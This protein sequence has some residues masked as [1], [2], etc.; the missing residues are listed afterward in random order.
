MKNGAKN[1]N[2]IDDAD[3]RAVRLPG[4]RVELLNKRSIRSD[5][6]FVLYWMQASIREQANGALELANRLGRQLERPTV[7]VFALTENYPGANLRHYRFLLEALADVRAALTKRGIR[8][9]VSLGEP[10]EVVE[11][12]ARD[13]ALLVTDRGY[14]RI[15]REWRAT[16]A[17]VVRCAMVQVEDNVVVPID[18]ASEKEEYAARTIRPKIMR[19]LEDYLDP[20]RRVGPYGSSIEGLRLPTGGNDVSKKLDRVERIL[21]KLSIDRSVSPSPCFTGGERAAKRHLDRFLRSRL[22]RYDRRNDPT[23]GVTSQLSPYLHFGCI[24]PVVVARR[25]LTSGSS[26]SESFI[27]E[28]CVR[29]ELAINFVVH[30]PQY[31]TIGSLPDWAE[32]TLAKHC[33]DRRP[34]LYT[35]E[36][37]RDAQTHDPAW[38]AAQREMVATGYMAGYMRMYWGKKVIEW[39][40]DPAEAYETLIRLN[41]TYELDGRD[42]NGYCGI[43]WCFGKH[44]RPWQERPIFGTVRTMVAA[45]LARKFNVE[46]YIEQVSEYGV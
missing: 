37:L 17:R 46:R 28:L 35:F 42:P 43:A 22:D 40:A 24:S 27:E 10:T 26:G 20:I 8:L 29:R 9:V 13:A 1:L 38:N 7:V 15:Q 14:T 19:R 16:L 44:D 6:R 18:V 41:D 25:A 45:G 11:R 33:R 3:L 36:Q 12:M 30:N 23:A 2:R 31:D 4:E 5:G 32:K 34:Y 21:E 39:T